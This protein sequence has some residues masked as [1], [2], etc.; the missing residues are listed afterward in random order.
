MD[1]KISRES[2]LAVMAAGGEWWFGEVGVGVGGERRLLVLQFDNRKSSAPCFSVNLPADASH[3]C[4]HADVMRKMGHEVAQQCRR[5][6]RVR[7]PGPGR[8]CMFLVCLRGT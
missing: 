6:L 5:R 3:S 4:P 8:V 2:I 7:F 1:R